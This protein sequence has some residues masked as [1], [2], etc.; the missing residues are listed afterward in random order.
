MSFD[1]VALQ[2]AL[3]NWPAPIDGA[4]GAASSTLGILRELLV[5]ALDGRPFAPA[6]FCPLVRQALLRESANGRRAEV[7]VPMGPDWPS[8]ADWARV[9]VRV[10]S[11]GNAAFLIGAEPP[12]LSFLGRGADLFDD[13]YAERLSHEGEHVPADPFIQAALGYEYYQSAG[14]REATRGLFLLPPGHTLIAA[15]PTGSGKSLLSQAPTLCDGWEGRL[16]VVIV[17]TVA[18][19]IDQ[20]R[21][22]RALM[23]R[24]YPNHDWSRLAYHG[25]LSSAEK[26][27]I[28]EAIRAG[29]QGILF[30]APESVCRSLAPSLEEAARRGFLRYFVIDEAHLVT[31][32]GDGFRLDFQLLSG[33]RRRLLQ[34]SPQALMKT[35]LI[36]ATLA[37]ETVETLF[38]LFGPRHT[39]QFLSALHLRPEPRYW[40]HEAASEEKRVE[41]VVEAARMA[42]RP[43]IL[44]VT[45][46]AEVEEWGSRFAALGHWRFATF[47]G[48]TDD[49]RRESILSRWSEGKL[50]SIIANSAFGLGVDK[51]NVRA[52]IH[53]TVPEG[54]DRFYQEVGRGGRDGKACASVIIWTASD[55]SL[56]RRLAAPRLIS[57]EVGYARWKSLLN[58][59]R[60]VPDAPGVLR[61]DLNQLVP[62]LVQQSESNRQWNIHTLLMATRAGLAE[63]VSAIDSAQ[64]TTGDRE[65]A[66]CYIR[67]LDHRHLNEAHWTSAVAHTR[68]KSVSRARH[69]LRLLTGV[70]RQPER[71][72]VCESL[73][74]LYTSSLTGAGTSVTGCCGGCPAHW[75]QRSETVQYR[76]PIATIATDIDRPDLNL[77][78]RRV[79]REHGSQL[80]VLYQRQ[81]MSAE[82]LA[83][84]VAQIL[85]NAPIQEV[86]IEGELPNGC[87]RLLRSTMQSLNNPVFVERIRSRSPSNLEF[88]TGTTRLTIIGEISGPPTSLQDASAAYNVFLSPAD[89]P[90]PYH[91]L[92]AFGAARLDCIHLNDLM[93]SLRS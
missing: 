21:R 36:S 18:L 11:V 91:P 16:T 78:R 66:T 53:A 49:L 84:S 52:I 24:R 85:R 32:W 25:G 37:S 14:Q 41:L 67:V 43:F 15:L 47:H 92:R 86:V 70:L 3:A 57:P 54:L 17:P 93:R 76:P 68:S 35:V 1:F 2:I 73:R 80:I 65:T 9:G 31:A 39:T 82:N 90:D 8:H 46:R 6:D 63:M 59:A 74:G 79:A 77:W 23:E 45:T 51:A 62:R 61:I 55:I 64:P 7:R 75:H 40:F 4:V 81:T 72:K 12:R 19:A 83:D 44:Y 60:S 13:A 69:N 29:A 22:M 34:A 33:L 42:P 28:R 50:D 38:E 58:N 89:L 20:A 30:A 87:D 71:E 5:D 48:G 88:R 10:T 56:A 27:A 26:A